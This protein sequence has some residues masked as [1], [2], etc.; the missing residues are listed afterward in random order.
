VGAY[1][2]FHWNPGKFNL[3]A[4]ARLDGH[5]VQTYVTDIPQPDTFNASFPEPA[6]AVS[7][8]FIPFS[9]NLGA[10][11]HLT[12]PLSV[13]AN[14][15]TGYA[16]P[17]YAQL[18]S[19]GRHEGTYRFEIG[20]NNLDMSQNLE[21]DLGLAYRK[22]NVKAELRAYSNRIDNYI[23]LAPTSDSVKDLKVYQWSQHDATINGIE[24]EFSVRPDFLKQVEW[25]AN[26]GALR[27]ELR[28]DNG[29]LPYIP[30]TK[31]ITGI[32]YHAGNEKWR[33]F[34]STF[35]FSAY[36]SQ[37]DVAAFESSTAG[38]CLTDL[39]FGVQPPIGKGHRWQLVL[40]CNNLFNKKYYSHTSLI[41]SIGV[42]EPG[43]NAGLQVG[44]KF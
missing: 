34:Y 4:G 15:A 8:R 9:F 7:R 24:F 20:D 17:N 27:G 30:A 25:F 42:S 38:Y 29:S 26:A 22:N 11:Y 16:S 23:F 19:F 36:G 13:K 33:D 5:H 43:R 21:A 37:D 35:Q 6:Q 31:L 28:D 10:V 18:T 40:F 3:L 44:Y 41:K 2:L 39:Y 1:G 32:T 14:L 12:D